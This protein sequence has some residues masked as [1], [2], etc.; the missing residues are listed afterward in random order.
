M[1]TF[2]VYEL[3]NAL[4]AHF[5]TDYDYFKYKGKVNVSPQTLEHRKD[6]YFFSK[7]AQ[8]NDPKGYIIANLIDNPNKWIGSFFYDEGQECYKKWQKRIESLTYTIQEECKVLDKDFDKNVV[9]LGHEHPQLLHRYLRGE[10]SLETLIILNEFCH[11]IG[12]WNKKLKDDPIWEETFFKLKKYRP[13]L[14]K[15]D[16]EKIKQVILRVFNE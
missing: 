12:Y 11:F 3:F 10:I 9:I 15:Y 13:F 8:K 1:N 7:L 14:P 16:K 2:Q 6:K 4:K 5:T